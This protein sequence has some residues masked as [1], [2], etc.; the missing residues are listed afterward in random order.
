MK[1]L[2]EYTKIFTILVVAGVT[3]TYITQHGL[4]PT[5]TST[6]LNYTKEHRKPVLQQQNSYLINFT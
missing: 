5:S 2:L 6:V 3:P 1:V 4:H